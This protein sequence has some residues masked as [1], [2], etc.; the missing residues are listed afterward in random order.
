MAEGDAR[1]I[2]GEFSDYDELITAL[3][4]RAAELNLSGADTDRLSGL[5]DRYSQKLLGPNQVRRLGVTSMGCFLGA[6]ALRGVLVED[7]AALEKL[8]RRTTPR[9]NQFV[10]AGAT[11]VT[12]TFRFMQKIGRLGAQARIDNSTKQQRSAWARK[13]AN[14]RWREDP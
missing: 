3:R 6:L 10:R 14:A 9:Q 1:K 11:H 5:P 12:L 4:Q 7:R 13:A 8:R 2:V